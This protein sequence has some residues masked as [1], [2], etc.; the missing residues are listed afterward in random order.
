MDPARRGDHAARGPRTSVPGELSSS[1]GRQS[2]MVRVSFRSG[3][4]RKDDPAPPP[5]TGVLTL[6][7]AGAADLL[8]GDL[9]LDDDRDRRKTRAAD[10]STSPLDT[11]RASLGGVRVGE[12]YQL[13]CE[14]GDG[15]SAGQVTLTIRI[16]GF[17]LA[18]GQAWFV[19][20][21]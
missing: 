14:R 10:A 7:A 13:R 18:H 16:T 5:C 12:F 8:G 19:G 21:G 9:D 1:D 20:L 2:W 11:D 6:A 4:P 17:D 3:P 15:P